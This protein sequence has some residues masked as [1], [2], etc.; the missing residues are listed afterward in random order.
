MQNEM[1]LLIVNPIS[2][3]GRARVLWP[4]ISAKM[5]SLF[6]RFEPIFT[7]SSTDA[8]EQARQAVECGFRHLIAV[9]GDGTV[10]EVVNGIFLANA[11]DRAEVRLGIIPM[12]SGDDF[13]KSLKI[14]ISP[15]DAIDRLKSDKS[16]LVDIGKVSYRGNNGENETRYFTNIADFGL[17]G[18]VMRKVNNSSKPLGCRLTYLY[19][20]TQS[21]L[22]YKAVPIVIKT[23]DQT[24]RFS[25]VILG[26]IANGKY[27]A[28]G[29]CV[30]PNASL[31]DGRFQV[32]VIEKLGLSRFLKMVPRLYQ[33]KWIEAK[34]VTRFTTS[35]LTVESRQ[36]KP[37]FIE[38]DGEQP[39][40]LPA[41]FEIMP[42]SLH[43]S[44]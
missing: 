1:P 37:V 7:R 36:P 40:S 2:G 22:T 18:E 9:G 12:G 38:A 15:M 21:F 23:D 31:E 41:T 30:S 42:K 10:H 3:K 43:I 34:G 16:V 25:E 4:L 27:F 14:P 28:N 33:G 11:K 39:G 13:V 6:G 17:G 32:I 35:K 44:V 24:Y 8:I 5:K 20:A 19:Y 26:I 29:L